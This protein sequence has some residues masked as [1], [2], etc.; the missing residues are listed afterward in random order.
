MNLGAAASSSFRQRDTLTAKRVFALFGCLGLLVLV[1]LLST[2]VHQIYWAT[3]ARLFEAKT[4]V[5]APASSGEQATASGTG[6]RKAQLPS[7]TAREASDPVSSTKIQQQQQQQN[8][9]REPEAAK[10]TVA[11]SLLLKKAKQKVYNSVWQPDTDDDDHDAQQTALEDREL[12]NTLEQPAHLSQIPKQAD[13]PQAKPSSKEAGRSNT[14]KDSDQDA[15]AHPGLITSA[16]MSTLNTTDI[17]DVIKEAEELGFEAAITSHRQLPAVSDTQAS[18]AQESDMA[19]NFTFPAYIPLDTG[20]NSTAELYPSELVTEEDDQV[21]L[22]PAFGVGHDQDHGSLPKLPSNDAIGFAIDDLDAS[23]P[24]STSRDS[25]EAMIAETEEE[26]EGEMSLF[27][28]QQAHSA[29]ATNDPEAESVSEADPSKVYTS[30]EA[31]LEPAEPLSSQIH[32][33]EEAHRAVATLGMKPVKAEDHK[34]TKKL[35]LKVASEGT[36]MVTWANFH[37]LDFTL[38]WVQHVQAANISAY[39][40]GAMD[41]E[42]LQALLERGINC[43]GMQ[44]GLSIDDFGWGSKQFHKMGRE[45]IGLVLTFTN[46]G[47]DVVVSDVDTVWLQDPLPYL[48]NYPEADVLVSSD[49]LHA[50]TTDGALEMYPGAGVANIGIMLF[51]SSAMMFA[52]EWNEALLAN[53]DYWDQNAFNDL[54][55]R[56]AKFDEQRSDRLFMGFDGKLRM[57][58]LPVSTFCSG[59][60]FFV[61]R[62]AD[63]MGLQPYVVHATFQFSGTPGKRHRMRESLLWDADPPEYFRPAGGLLTFDMHLGDLVELSAPHQQVLHSVDNSQAVPRQRTLKLDADKTGHFNLVNAQ[64]QQVRTAMAIASSLNRTLVMPQLWCGMDRWWAPHDSNIPGSSLQLPFQCPMDHIFDLEQ[65]IKHHPVEALGPHIDWREHSLLNN[66]LFPEEDL[67]AAAHVHICLGGESDCHDGSKQVVLSTGASSSSSIGLQANL[68][69]Q[70]LQT[71]LASL[72]ETAV[73]HFDSMMGAF[74][75]HANH[76][77]ASRFQRRTEVYTSLW[78]C[79]DAHPGHVWYDMWWDQIPHEDRHKRQISDAWKPSTGP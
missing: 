41:D 65:M 21:G 33:E 37:Y 39:L 36:V 29:A 24:V 51:R 35:I 76:G 7:A 10:D 23:Q 68:T 40:V 16:N 52:Q 26:E 32:R 69:D 77:D 2:P 30:E 64:I 79:V 28:S 19:A 75:G 71:A 34:L 55:N 27:A 17:Q 15:S 46:M 47:F 53:D 25:I 14:F 66:P 9:R 18:D 8:Y 42:L 1:W 50:T 22:V 70:Q 43:F 78:C 48:A 57:G 12:L 13:L 56:G 74:G 5:L 44:S 60:T 6:A 38:N 20:I 59:H 4:A 54:M 72:E 49:S 62:M 11:I 67:A 61:Q 31:A 3:Q 58:I 63:V 45:K 73:L